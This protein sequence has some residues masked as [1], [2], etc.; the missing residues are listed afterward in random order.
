MIGT[1]FTDNIYSCNLPPKLKL[2]LAIAVVSKDN[3]VQSFM[4]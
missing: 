3:V 4:L 1:H 2:L